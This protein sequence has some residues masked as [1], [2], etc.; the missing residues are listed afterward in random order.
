MQ[1]FGVLSISHTWKA[2]KMMVLVLFP[3]LFSADFPS[4]PM[5]F[6]RTQPLSCCWLL[7]SRRPMSFRIAWIGGFLWISPVFYPGFIQSWGSCTWKIWGNRWEPWWSWWTGPGM[8]LAKRAVLHGAKHGDSVLI[9][10][11]ESSSLWLLYQ[12]YYIVIIMI[13]ISISS[14]I[15][16]I[17]NRYASSSSSHLILFSFLKSSKTSMFD[18]TGV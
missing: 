13:K 14:I 8:S 2:G 10:S 11:L 3:M 1:F 7:S 12:Y 4:L 17:I 15:I 5:M 18:D 6:A 16:I 9:P